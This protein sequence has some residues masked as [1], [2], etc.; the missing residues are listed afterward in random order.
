[1]PRPRLS[2]IGDKNF[3]FK[4]TALCSVNGLVTPSGYSR[5]DSLT[6]PAS[7]ASPNPLI[8]KKYRTTGTI[9]VMTPEQ[10]PIARLSFWEIKYEIPK[11][12]VQVFLQTARRLPAAGFPQP[13]RQHG[14]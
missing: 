11:R 3:S 8:S 13:A 1:M 5:G 9:L 2:P 7:H 12:Q 14:T 4:T 6:A 10:C